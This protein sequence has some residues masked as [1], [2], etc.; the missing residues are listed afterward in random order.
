M[1]IC[2]SV[3]FVA[4]DLIY[5]LALPLTNL[6]FKSSKDRSYEGTEITAQLLSDIRMQLTLCFVLM[7]LVFYYRLSLPKD[8]PDD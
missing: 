4:V 7:M 6:K 8:I 2:M 3:I 5:C 1:L